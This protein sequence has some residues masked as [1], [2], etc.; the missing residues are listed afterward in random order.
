[1]VAKKK[2]GFW[3]R[4]AIAPQAKKETGFLWWIIKIT[5]G[6]KEETRFLAT[7]CDRASSQKKTGFLS[8]I[9]K[10]TVLSKE[11]T[12]FLRLGVNCG[13]KKPG[14]CLWITKITVDSKEETRF[15]GI[16]DA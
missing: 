15:L 2:P 6:S 8:C 9:I 3:P 7:V 11:E 10:I 14:L 5:F 16:A 12:R 13:D 4:Y 1:L